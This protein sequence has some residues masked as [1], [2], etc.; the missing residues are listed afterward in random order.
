MRARS[1]IRI[2][3]RAGFTLI[4]LIL[5]IG[6]A[7]LILIVA[8]Q[9]L[10]TS[11]RLRDRVS[12]AVESSAPLE[13]ALDTIRLDLQGVVTP[14]TNGLLS[15]S[16]R[17][18]SL[19]STVNS[20]PVSLEFNTTTGSLRDD[21]PWGVVQRV[22]YSLRSPVESGGGALDLY[23]GVCRNLL[24]LS[25]AEV[26]DQLLLRDVSRIDVEAFD[27]LQWL[28]QWDTT[29]TSGSTT[30][31]PVAVRIRLQRGP[32]WGVD[33]GPVELLVPLGVQARTNSTSTV[34]G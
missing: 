10:F 24:P 30:N 16:F 8:N 33:S 11:L 9:V 5:S 18:G 15:G 31:L 12:Q 22:S 21:E 6:A 26:E 23:R 34:G 13:L 29:G 25:V 14:K 28:Q 4:E 32:T 17:A 2:R 27:G 20:Q 7:A 3:P 19:Q 1:S